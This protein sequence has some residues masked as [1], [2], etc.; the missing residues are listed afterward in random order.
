[1]TSTLTYASARHASAAVSRSGAQAP[2]QRDHRGHQIRSACQ[3]RFIAGLP[4]QI[5]AGLPDP[6]LRARRVLHHA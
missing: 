5:Q 2:R 3:A 1:M 6:E 4:G